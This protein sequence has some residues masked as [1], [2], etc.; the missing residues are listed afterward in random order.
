[1]TEPSLTPTTE[2]V[3]ECKSCFATINPED[4]FC[5][6]C[7]FPLKGSAE[8]QEKF[9]YNRQYANVEIK[10]MNE[11]IKSAGTTL[12][13]LSGLFVLYGLIYFFKDSSSD[14]SSALLITNAAIAIIF[15]LLGFWSTKKP[16]ASIIS[17]MVLYSLVLILSAIDNPLNLVQG[18]IFKIA[19]ISYLIKGLLS[20]LEAE[21]LRKLHNI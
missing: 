11:K 7:G 12:Y 21:K 4:S 9:L 6:A 14:D 8:Q 3:Q 18:I 20:A 5:Q 2:L 1:M 17:G 10:G 15:L 19:I 13:V 16:V